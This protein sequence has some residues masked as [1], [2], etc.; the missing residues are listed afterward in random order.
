MTIPRR[1]V[2]S[3]IARCA[4]GLMAFGSMRAYPQEITWTASPKANIVPAA[5]QI[6]APIDDSKK[7]PAIPDS[8]HRPAPLVPSTVG[9]HP[10]DL[11]TALRLANSQNPTI[12][13]AMAQVRRAQA[14]QDQ[15]DV[16]WLPNLTGGGT[17]IRHDGQTQNQAGVV[18]GV[19]RSSVFSGGGSQLRIDTSDALFQPLVARRITGAASNEARATVNSIQLD[20]ALGYVDLLQSYGLL[21]INQDSL[22]RAE[23]ML[24]LAAAAQKSGV[25]KTAGDINRARAEVATR[26]MDRIDLEG[27]AAV[28]SARLN[29]L[30][31]LEASV[32]LV[33]ADDAIT[34]I[35][36]VPPE[37]SLDDLVGL[38]IRNRPELAANRDLALAALERL[39]QARYGPLFPRVQIDYLA[40]T[41]GGGRNSFVGTFSGR[42]DLGAQAYW[43][44]RNFGLGNA[45]Q[46]RERAADRDQA[47]LQGVEIEARIRAEVIEALKVSQARAR[48]LTE[49]QDAVRESAELYR[50][51]LATQFGMV[52]PNAR[53]DPLEALLAIQALFQARVQY[54]NQVIDYNRY[55]LRLF[56]ALGSPVECATADV[57]SPKIE[58]PVLPVPEPTKA[59]EK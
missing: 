38:A 56:A 15:A 18:F 6:V 36:L 21:A 58:I 54:L 22:T 1:S 14:Q 47:I 8:T 39:R 34:P 9:K 43:E 30:L 40:G 59:K 23:K 44:L 17:Y 20:V 35:T 42:G 33:P 11:E 51:L 41:F 19:S 49:A 24:E 29:R 52:G 53:Y 2:G 10:I 3:S 50:K 48:A 12:G 31:L 13:R 46:M 32:E 57:P 45:A 37:L 4:I 55:Q 16:L 5:L 7:T 25:S 28:A 27:R 26:R